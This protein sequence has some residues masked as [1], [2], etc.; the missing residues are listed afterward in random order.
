MF[1]F[2]SPTNSF[3]FGLDITRM[4]VHCMSTQFESYTYFILCRA[5]PSINL[6]IN[7][8]GCLQ[9]TPEETLKALTKSI[10]SK[11]FGPSNRS[12]PQRF[13]LAYSL[14]EVDP[15]STLVSQ[16]LSTFLLVEYGRP[17]SFNHLSWI[18]ASLEELLPAVSSSFQLAVYSRLIHQYGRCK[19][20]QWG[21]W[22]RDDHASNPKR[23]SRCYYLEEAAECRTRANH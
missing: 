15:T 2:R 3:S 4:S 8:R 10:A 23:P 14:S 16:S 1:L 20:R 11:H 18:T 17:F 21:S 19:R 6:R 22:R 5:W 7:Y 13:F 12:H 9:Q